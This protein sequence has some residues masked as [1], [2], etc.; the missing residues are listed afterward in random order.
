[1]NAQ[2]LDALKVGCDPGQPDLAES[3]CDKVVETI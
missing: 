3:S 2:S 1:M